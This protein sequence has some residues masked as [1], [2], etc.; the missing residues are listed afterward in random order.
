M[1]KSPFIGDLFPWADYMM[2]EAKGALTDD[3]DEMFSCYTE[4][5]IYYAGDKFRTV[6]QGVYCYDS[7]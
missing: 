4:L 3:E 1:R 2:I 7:L 5:E 6:K